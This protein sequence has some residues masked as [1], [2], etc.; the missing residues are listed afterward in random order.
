MTTSLVPSWPVQLARDLWEGS[1]VRFRTK[2]AGIGGSA[3][4]SDFEKSFSTLAHVYLRDKAPS[5]LKY[6]VGFQLI[7]KNEDNTKAAGMAV[8]RAGGQWFYVPIMFISGRI[9]GHELLYLKD[10]DQFVPLKDNWIQELLNKKPSLLGEPIQGQP[11]EHGITAPDLQSLRMPRTKFA[12]HIPPQHLQAAAAIAHCLASNPLTL[13]KYA[14]IRSLPKFLE[15]APLAERLVFARI[16]H[17]Y[18]A[19]AQKIFAI[20]K[21]ANL[22]KTVRGAITEVRRLNQNRKRVRPNPELQRKLEDQLRN[23][24]S[25]REGGVLEEHEPELTKQ[26]A[27]IVIYSVRSSISIPTHLSDAEKEELLRKGYKVEDS[28]SGEQKSKAYTLATDLRLANPTQT[29][30][31]DVFLADG[32]FERCLV[33]TNPF[34][35]LNPV[36]SIREPYLQDEDQEAIRRLSDMAL[37]VRLSDKKYFSCPR[38]KVYVKVSSDVLRSDDSFES[39]YKDLPTLWN[40]LSKDPY[41]YGII[42]S[43][44]G[45]GTMPISFNG[46]LGEASDS[47][48]IVRGSQSVEGIPYHFLAGSPNGRFYIRRNS[49]SAP[50]II[51]RERQGPSPKYL[52]V[53]LPGAAKFLS[54]AESRQAGCCCSVLSGSEKDMFSEAGLGKPALVEL[55]LG[56]VM[57]QVKVASIQRGRS[58]KI[59][60]IFCPDKVD[61][62]TELLL[63]QGFDEKTA[64]QILKEADEKGH[65]SVFVKRA[66]PMPPGPPPPPGQM[67]GMASMLQPGPGAPPMPDPTMVAMPLAGGG[68]VNT[69]SPLTAAVPAGLPQQM[70]PNPYELP[71]DPM[72]SQTLAQAAQS[73][74]KEILDPAAIGAILRYSTNDNLVDQYIPELMAALDRLGRILLAFYW[75]RDQFQE[76]YGK[77]DLPELEDSLRT[78]FER[79]GDLV[80]TLKQRMIEPLPGE[81]NRIDLEQQVET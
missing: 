68:S 20:H 42:L 24:V 38:S 80:L 63:G 81:V 34:S 16:V 49:Y 1:L 58:Y 10:L 12:A 72:A 3:N 37:L 25:S 17:D 18:P 76:R 71:A 64:E 51:S 60:H 31:Y 15:S 41:A 5:L 57:P 28:R 29:G 54:L 11:G 56:A 23:V 61:A 35:L 75:H 22:E 30:I 48:L 78:N 77:Q 26:S 43:P 13:Q 47:T 44:R 32:T 14:S 39:F 46:D 65:I 4:E 7:D 70:P 59:N 6:E 69:M 27:A 73:G 8:F 53:F 55:A 9:K 2:E 79:L 50:R 21:S 62:V 36:S 66:Q 33:V 67:P 74:Q 45:S 52:D 40:A 19:V